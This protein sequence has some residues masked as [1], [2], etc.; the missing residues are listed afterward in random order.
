MNGRPWRSNGILSDSINGY[1]W[2]GMIGNLRRLRKRL[3]ISF[4]WCWWRKK[5]KHL[6]WNKDHHRSICNKATKTDL[7]GSISI[8][9]TT[10]H[11]TAVTGK[12]KMRVIGEN[13]TVTRSRVIFNERHFHH[14]CQLSDCHSRTIHQG[15]THLVGNRCHLKKNARW[16]VSIGNQTR[17]S[18]WVE[19]KRKG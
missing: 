16:W 8:N 1:R 15:V 17:H 10:T 18:S 9:M 12:G 19:M 7:W 14:Q 11:W 2:N 13:K 6:I 5:G 3:G 4:R